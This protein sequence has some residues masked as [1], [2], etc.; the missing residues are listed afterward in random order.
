MQAKPEGDF[1]FE[2]TGSFPFQAMIGWAA[3]AA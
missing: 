2:K 1:S 3:A